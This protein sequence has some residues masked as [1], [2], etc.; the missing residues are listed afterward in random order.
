MT[1][2]EDQGQNRLSE[3]EEIA[4]LLPWYVSGKLSAS[5]RAKV[6]AYGARHPELAAH[7][8]I[9][10]AE[11]DEVFA[12]NSAITAPRGGLARLQRSLAADPRANARSV[13]IARLSLIDRIG[14]V[15]AALT[16][17]QLAYA[18]VAGLFALALQTGVISALLR[19][20]VTG[21]G[22]Y[23]TATGPGGA[24]ATSG[25]YA[26]VA[27]QPG[28]PAGTV[29]AFLAEQKIVVVDGP[30]AGGLYRVRLSAEALPADARDA[31]IAKLKARADLVSFAGAAPTTP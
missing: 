24:A 17:R 11:A 18:S 5:D 2:N 30:R 25:T 15:L 23:E 29:T 22:G 14:A 6:D 8:A 9:A 3:A 12:I 1:M 16:P 27:F 7:I 21:S 28:A 20:P 26:L 31:A 4:A 10:R 13:S 19:T